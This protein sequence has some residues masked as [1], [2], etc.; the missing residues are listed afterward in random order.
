MNKEILDGVC[1]IL[2]KNY[3][4]VFVRPNALELS[5]D[6]DYLTIDVRKVDGMKASNMAFASKRILAKYPQ[7]K[8]V[9][10]TGGWMEHVYTRETLKWLG[11]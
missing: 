3:K 7:V 5:V 9:H 1:R 4:G 8:Y 11:H 2:E 10:F 6:D